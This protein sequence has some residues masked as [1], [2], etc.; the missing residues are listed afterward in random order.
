MAAFLLATSAS[1]Q[2]SSAS[3]AVSDAA[4]AYPDILSANITAQVGRADLFLLI[5]VAERIPDAPAESFLSW[6]WNLDTDPTTAPGGAAA[7]LFVRS[8]YGVELRRFC[9]RSPPATHRW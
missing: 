6:T 7:E 3:D 4:P 2:T 8:L 5:E 1:A 9:H